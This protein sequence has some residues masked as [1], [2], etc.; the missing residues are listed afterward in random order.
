MSDI[1]SNHINDPLNPNRSYVMFGPSAS[2][3][4]TQS[5]LLK[6]VL[7]NKDKPADNLLDS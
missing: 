6:E 7:E 2:G 3:K 1:Q 4:G 5:V